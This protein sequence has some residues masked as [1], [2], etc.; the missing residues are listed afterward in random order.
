MRITLRGRFICRTTA[1]SASSLHSSAS[2]ELYTRL[3]ESDLQLRD[4]KTPYPRLVNS[5][6]ISDT[7]LFLA[8]TSLRRFNHNEWDMAQSVRLAGR[9][10]AR[11]DAGKKLTF[12]DLNRG[13]QTAQ[14]VVNALHY[15]SHEEDIDKREKIQNEKNNLLSILSIGDIIGTYLP[16]LCLSF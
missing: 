14:I 5:K 10:T 3:R 13:G 15:R 12:L 2:N 16:H 8:E 4:I 11:R 6:G 7:K 1:A 9:I